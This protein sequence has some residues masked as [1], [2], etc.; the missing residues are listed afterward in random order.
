M[1]AFVPR[2]VCGPVVE[3]KQALPHMSCWHRSCDERWT[4]VRLNTWPEPCATVNVCQTGISDFRSLLLYGA[5]KAY[6]NWV[7]SEM[8]NLVLMLVLVFSAFMSFGQLEF[9]GVGQQYFVWKFYDVEVF[10]SFSFFTEETNKCCITEI[11]E[12]LFTRNVK[13]HEK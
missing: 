2:G 11:M 9:G 4:S 6:D 5:E 1:Y 8:S 3:Y 12:D 10:F 13:Q 7:Q